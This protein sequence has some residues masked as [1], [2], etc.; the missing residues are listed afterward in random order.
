MK[1]ADGHRL[2]DLL[3][4]NDLT[5]NQ[6]GWELVR[7]FADGDRRFWGDFRRHIATWLDARAELVDAGKRARTWKGADNRSS[8]FAALLVSAFRFVL[9]NK[10][11]MGHITVRVDA[12][13]VTRNYHYM[14]TSAMAQFKAGSLFFERR[15]AP[16]RAGGCPGRAVCWVTI[17]RGS[18][19]WSQHRHD[20]RYLRGRFYLAGLP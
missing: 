9:Q 15:P 7:S 12:G 8:T 5:I 14:A 19:A 3:S 16:V 11:P 20:P 6:Q 17:D 2:L 1:R 10:I 4:A 18:A 13:G